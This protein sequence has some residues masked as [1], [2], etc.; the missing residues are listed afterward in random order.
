MKQTY[1][2]ILDIW[3]R[4]FVAVLIIFIITFLVRALMIF[5]QTV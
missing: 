4:V 3:I 1:K 2:Y 5:R